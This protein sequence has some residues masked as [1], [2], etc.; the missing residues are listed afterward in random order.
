MMNIHLQLLEFL[1]SKLDE[2]DI[3]VLK[4]IIGFMPNKPVTQAI[5]HPDHYI[6]RVRIH[7]K[8]EFRASNIS[9]L[10]YNRDTGYL[11]YQKDNNIF[12]RANLPGDSIFYGALTTPE[13]PENY[14]TAWAETTKMGRNKLIPEEYFTVS[15]WKIVKNFF[16]YEL[17]FMDNSNVFDMVNKAR[18]LQ[19]GFLKNLESPLINKEDVIKKLVY[20]GNQFRKE[21]DA[22][23]SFDYKISAA[24][25]YMMLNHPERQIGMEALTYPSVKM[26]GLGLNIAINPMGVKNYLKFEDAE[27]MKAERKP[28][29]VRIIRGLDLA[30]GCDIN[31]KLIWQR[32]NN[33]PLVYQF[34]PS[35]I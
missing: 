16:G 26:N 10:S 18:E 2:V 19:S 25:A 28:D 21:V 20:F 13:V 5:F 24:F 11:S 30:S 4:I 9:E 8:P 17:V 1:E 14:I 7:T 32:G 35:S 27:V 23:R 6:A 29:G 15:W 34:S 33:E 31:G 22:D 12:G 3:E